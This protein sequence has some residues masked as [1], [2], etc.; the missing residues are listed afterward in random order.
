VRGV[1]WINLGD[2]M[3]HLLVLANKILKNPIL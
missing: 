2:E 3:A 1:D